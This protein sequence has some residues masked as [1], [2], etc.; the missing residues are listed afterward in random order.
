MATGGRL[1][2]VT[3]T[4]AGLCRSVQVCAGSK[5]LVFSADSWH[6][7]STGR[8]TATATVC[9]VHSPQHCTHATDSTVAFNCAVCSLLLR[10]T[11]QCSAVHCTALH[12]SAVQCSVQVGRQDFLASPGRAARGR[13]R[14]RLLPAAGHGAALHCSLLSSTVLQCTTVHNTVLH[15]SALCTARHSPSPH[16]SRPAPAAR[17]AGQ[18]AAAGLPCLL[19]SV[20]C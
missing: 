18:A 13:Q 4:L 10:H 14:S 2:A 5:R 6:K 16:C 17:T 20:K 11:V 1:L 12:C 3:V 8:I 15:I 19:C 7:S 9:K